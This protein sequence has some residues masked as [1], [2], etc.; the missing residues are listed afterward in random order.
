M[1]SLFSRDSADGLHPAIKISVVVLT[2][3]TL[4]TFALFVVKM[5]NRTITPSKVT[6]RFYEYKIVGDKLKSAGLRDQAIA[7][8]ET[9]LQHDKVD[10]KTRSQVSQTVAELYMETGNCRKALGWLYHAEIAAG[11]ERKNNL[12]TY[13]ETCLKRIESNGAPESDRQ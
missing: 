3:V 1:N 12:N 6:S 2:L 10:G 7:Q 13:I 5:L 8:Y 9:F 11:P 4:V